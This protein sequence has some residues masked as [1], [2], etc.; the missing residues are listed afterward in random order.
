[1]VVQGQMREREAVREFVPAGLAST[2]NSMPTR[3]STF[4]T[5]LAARAFYRRLYIKS[6]QAGSVVVK[7]GVHSDYSDAVAA[8]VTSGRG[9]GAG[10]GGLNANDLSDALG[11]PVEAVRAPSSAGGGGGFGSIGN[12]TGRAAL[13]AAILFPILFALIL[14]LCWRWNYDWCKGM[15]SSRRPRSDRPASS[16]STRAKAPAAHAACRQAS[17]RRGEPSPWDDAAEL[18]EAERLATVTLC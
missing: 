13:A 5:S 10:D 4:L 18:P 7:V 8:A 17:G 14:I 6:V 16:R 9:D 2:D 12:L 3:S 15:H 11:A 1:M